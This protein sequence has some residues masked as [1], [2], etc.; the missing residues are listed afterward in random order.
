MSE[1]KYNNLDEVAYLFKRLFSTDDG[2]EVYRILEQRFRTPPLCP[3][4]CADGM[5]IMALT[6]M[7]VGEDNVIRYID[8]L[9]KREVEK[10]E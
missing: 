4:S 2:K 1:N 8:S 6:Q 10:H 9:T 5:A 3:Q 7:R